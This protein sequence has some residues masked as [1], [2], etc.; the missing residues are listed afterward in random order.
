MKQLYKKYANW[1]VCILVC[2]FL[3]KNCQSCGRG[4]M[5]DYHQKQYTAELTILRDS[6]DGLH[7]TIDSL[8][9][10]ISSKDHEINYLYDNNKYLQN[11]NIQYA[12]TN[13]TLII[14]NK[15]IINKEK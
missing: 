5:I 1:I 8:Y 11:A 7:K 6:I 9:N 12:K 14:T 15:E 13:R 4:K 3:F 10:T 2:L